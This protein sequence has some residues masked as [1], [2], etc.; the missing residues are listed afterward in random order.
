MAQLIEEVSVLA[1]DR[2][3]KEPRSIPRPGREAETQV[4]K[5]GLHA[6]A[7]GGMQAVGLQGMLALA[8]QHQGQVSFGA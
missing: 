3:R 4:V 6:T 8:K 2:R 5:T 1:A 7:T